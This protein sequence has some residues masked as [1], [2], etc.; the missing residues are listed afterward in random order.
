M[1]WI[2][3]VACFFYFNSYG[4]LKDY[5]IGV[6][7]DTL[8]R[9]DNNGK[10]Q[11]K[12]VV[13]YTEV[14]GEPGFE[15]EG[16]YKDS[17]KEGPWR[18]YTLTGD[19]FAVENYRW[20]FKDGLNQYFNINGELLKE[21][22]WKALNPDK[23]Y[24]T[25]DVEDI[26]NQGQ[27]KRVIVK[28]EGASIKNGTWRYFDPEAGFITKTEFWQLGKLDD[29]GNGTAKRPAADSSS[30]VKTKVKPKEVLDFEK[31]N[32]GKKKVRVRDGSTGN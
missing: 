16:L 30:A 5:I 25:I 27:F 22:N 11:G 21:E 32:A 23:L 29:S 7:G 13:R 12:W 10:K 14:R 6:K 3:I 18:K 2:L 1:R 26:N 9:V 20:G 8:N 19:L 17:R 15:E 28:N 4:Q 31:K 24:D